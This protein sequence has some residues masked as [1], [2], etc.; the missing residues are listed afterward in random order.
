MWDLAGWCGWR[1][2]APPHCNCTCAHTRRP[3]LRCQQSKSYIV[4]PFLKSSVCNGV[5]SFARKRKWW[6][7]WITRAATFQPVP[8]VQLRWNSCKRCRWSCLLLSSGLL[9]SWIL[10]SW[11]SWLFW[12]HG[13]P[14][15]RRGKEFSLIVLISA[16]QHDLWTIATDPGGDRS[17]YAV[18][19]SNWFLIIWWV[20]TAGV[21]F[22]TSGSYIVTFVFVQIICVCSDSVFKGCNHIQG[23]QKS[24]S[25]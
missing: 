2:C 22:V 1:A 17:S 16:H 23:S 10:L 25:Q 9:L 21:G 24:Q 7:K 15:R 6:L 4:N 19:L 11:A 12:E 18:Q 20:L 3:F 13:Q 14:F 8:R 5:V